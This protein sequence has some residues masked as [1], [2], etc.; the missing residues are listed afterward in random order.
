VTDQLVA[1][2]TDPPRLGRGPRLAIFV[3]VCVLAAAIAAGALWAARRDRD[4]AVTAAAPVDVAE[5]PAV[6]PGDDPV[7]LFESTAL[8]DTYGMVSSTPLDSPGG[9]RTVS[10]LRCERVDY[11]SGRGVCLQSDRG[12]LTTYDALVFDS[13]LA[14]RHTI[15]LAGAPSRVRV[16]P[17]GT[18]AGV[19]VFVTGHS[20]AN[21]NFSTQTTLLDLERGAVVADLEADFTVRRDGE[22]WHAIDFNFWGVTFVDEG[23]FY[24]TL[25][26]GGHTYLVSGDLEAREMV[27][28]RDGVECP[29]L[30]PD[31]TRVAFKIRSDGG[32]GPVTWG[33]AVL[34]LATDEVTT[35]A[36][37]GNV[38]DQVA[39]LDDDTVMYGMPNEQSPAESD[40]WIVPADG[41]GTPQVF[42]PRSWSAVVTD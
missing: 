9:A 12:V 29:S 21:G 7:L 39:W 11:R 14:V 8:G 3:A 16:S 2:P 13:D 36:E 32:S 26:T 19:T 18:M 10:D 42:I 15:G 27:V 20:Y 5:A 41:T 37:T 35:L 33:I 25:G 24:A 34:D 1:E 38:D 28:E 30:S 22:A 40:T 17:G 4:R 23:H 31:G 6:L